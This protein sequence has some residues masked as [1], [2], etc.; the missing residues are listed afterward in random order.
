MRWRARGRCRARTAGRARA[1][2][3]PQPPSTPGKTPG[4]RDHVSR[5][6]AGAAQRPAARSGRCAQVCAA[7]GARSLRGRLALSA[8]LTL[9]A[10][11][12]ARRRQKNREAAKR[13]RERRVNAIK[14]LSDQ[15]RRDRLR[16]ALRVHRD[17]RRPLRPARQI[18]HAPA[19]AAARRP[20]CAR[21]RPPPHAKQH[22]PALSPIGRPAAGRQRAA[23]R[24]GHRRRRR[25]DAAH[26]I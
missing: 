7:C 3:A 5:P 4:S 9:V 24:R 8:Q 17:A 19:C 13:V 15:A 23:A 22:H 12:P 10:P 2:E 11:R 18:M 16:E 26:P 6:A 1:Q 20:A 21:M 14:T 25:R